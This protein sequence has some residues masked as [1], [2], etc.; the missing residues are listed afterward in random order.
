MQTYL[1]WFRANRAR[2]ETRISARSRADAIAEFA[3][4]N[5]CQPSSYI[6]ARVA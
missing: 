6:A 5:D 3:R 2:T 1:V 4:R